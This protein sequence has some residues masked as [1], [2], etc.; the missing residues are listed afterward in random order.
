MK[1]AA[2][3][4]GSFEFKKQEHINFFIYKRENPIKY[5]QWMLNAF[6]LG[7]DFHRI[8]NNYKTSQ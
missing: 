3:K 7:G 8:Y 1:V 4:V 6:C 2:D 5:D